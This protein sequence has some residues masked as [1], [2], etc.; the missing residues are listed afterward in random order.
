[1]PAKGSVAMRDQQ[2]ETVATAKGGINIKVGGSDQ[3]DF[4]QMPKRLPLRKGIACLSRYRDLCG[5]CNG[6]KASS[7]R[8]AGVG[9]ST[10]ALCTA[11]GPGTVRP[12]SITARAL[13]AP[14]LLCSFIQLRLIRC[15]T[16]RRV[17]A[18]VGKLREVAHP[19]FYAEVT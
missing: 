5:Q 3:V 4:S 19:G 11:C 13:T 7:A 10:C 1:M 18:A 12:S 6:R 9:S 17:M 16:R 15:F 14:S 8:G 2:S